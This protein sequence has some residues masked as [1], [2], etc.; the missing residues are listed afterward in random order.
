MRRVFACLIAAGCCAAASA[1]PASAQPPHRPGPV[2]HHGGA[3]GAR[4]L[5]H[6]HGKPVVHRHDRIGHV[7]PDRHR[8]YRHGYGYGYVPG[9]AWTGEPHGTT[10]ID[11]SENVREAV[12][13][14]IPTVLGI[15]AAPAGKPTVYVLNAAPGAGAPVSARSRGPRVVELGEP[16]VS[17]FEDGPRVVHLSV[18]R[19]RPRRSHAR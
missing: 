11:R 8:G 7:R 12:E 18:P 2:V 6:R 1:G 17:S 13:P 5:P 10:I 19:D 16:Q 3:P 9:F 15:R 4:A 14:T